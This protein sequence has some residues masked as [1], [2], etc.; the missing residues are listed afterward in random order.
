MCMRSSLAGHR[1][2]SRPSSDTIVGWTS[3]CE[4]KGVRIVKSLK[5]QDYGQR[6]FVFA[7]PDGNRVDVGQRI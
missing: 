4:A 7:D 5:D 6:A 2:V 1:L 3:V